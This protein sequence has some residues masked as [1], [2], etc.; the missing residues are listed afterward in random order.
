MRYLAITALPI[1]IL[2]LCELVTDC[3]GSYGF[4]HL[5]ES[6]LSGPPRSSHDLKDLKW[7]KDVKPSRLKSRYDGRLENVLELTC[8]NSS[9]SYKTCYACIAVRL[10]ESFPTE[11]KN[12]Y[13]FKITIF[14]VAVYLTTSGLQISS[15]PESST[16]EPRPPQTTTSTTRAPVSSRVPTS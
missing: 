1:V 10:I 7:W 11:L 9:C 2:A 5:D 6:D 14:P 3:N 8:C 13:L 15:R 12:E 16:S 4:N